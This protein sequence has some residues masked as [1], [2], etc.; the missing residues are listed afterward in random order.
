VFTGSDDP[1]LRIKWEGTEFKVQSSM[2]KVRNELNVEPGT[3]NPLVTLHAGG[4]GRVSRNG[5]HQ[6]W[7]KAIVRFEAEFF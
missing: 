1:A 4:L 2:L 7:G 3:L 5:V 6:S